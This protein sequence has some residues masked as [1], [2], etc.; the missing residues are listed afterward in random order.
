VVETMIG[1]PRMLPGRRQWD[2]AMLGTELLLS[3]D[4]E[5]PHKAQGFWTPW[6]TIDIDVCRLTG[7]FARPRNKLC[8]RGRTIGRRADQVDASVRQIA[9]NADETAKV[10]TTASHTAKRNNDI[11]IKLGQSSLRSAM[12]SR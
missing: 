6:T 2:R 5:R 9:D 3:N 12:S 10:D 4:P 7:R 8:T 11:V 1:R